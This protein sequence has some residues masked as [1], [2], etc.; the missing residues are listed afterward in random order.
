MAIFHLSAKVIS[1]SSGRSAT[2]AAA[3]RAGQK[4][5]DMRTG[6]CFDYTRKK[7]VSYR[8]IFTPL[9]SPDWV[10]DRQKLW[11]AVELAELRKDAQVA[12]EVE[13][14]LPRELNSSQQIDLINR[15]VRSQFIKIG[16]VADVVIHDKEGNP[17]AHILLTTRDIGADGFSQKN[18]TWNSK[19]LLE[20]W[21]SQWEIQCNRRLSIAGHH[22]RIDHRS[23]EAQG[24]DR[25]PT[26]HIGTSSVAVKTRLRVSEKN[27]L[28]QFIKEKNMKH[29]KEKNGMPTFT[30]VEA[31]PSKTEFNELRKSKELFIAAN[32]YVNH[33]QYM[34]A[35]HSRSYIPRLLELF[36]EI[37]VGI[38]EVE[39]DM[40]SCYRID[41]QSG[42]VYDYGSQIKIEN[43][44]EEELRV[45]VQLAFEKGWKGLHLTGSK[46]FKEAMFLE[47]VIGGFF[48]PDQISGYIPSKENLEIVS[49][50]RPPMAVAGDR[51][52]IIKLIS[53]E[54]STS[55]GEGQAG[56]TTNTQNVPRLKL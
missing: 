13:V 31:I 18:R 51:E 26:V 33:K 29:E 21:R 54:K 27:K 16:M 3:Y 25:I 8:E 7:D 24:I 41:L 50:L 49:S 40:G 19:E 39:T 15:F 55:S 17:H 20:K 5:L 1:R 23:L 10:R 32:D 47:A 4:I 44:T 35:K 28:N 6:N 12:R 45:A 2:A 43:G 52:K 56:E 34:R 36:E 37:S 11:N 22:S 14:A 9:N 30:L 42:A 48:K 46:S 38:Y 53:S